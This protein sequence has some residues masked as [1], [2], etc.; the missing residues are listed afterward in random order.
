VCAL[1]PKC[2]KVEE[3]RE[4]LSWK[5]DF[6]CDGIKFQTK[7]FKLGGRPEDFVLRVRAISVNVTE[8]VKS[9]RIL[10]RRTIALKLTSE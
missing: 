4:F 3:V 10:Y 7:E 9:S 1:R 8:I 2:E 6:H 5:S